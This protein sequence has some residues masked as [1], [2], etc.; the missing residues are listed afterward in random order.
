MTS[1]LRS[2]VRY[3]RQIGVIETVDGYRF[4]G[5]RIIEFSQV[6]RD[7]LREVALR[8]IP[9]ERQILDNWVALQ[10]R[11]WQPPGLSRDDLRQVFGQFLRNV[12]RRL[13]AQEVE[14]CTLD[15][16]ETGADLAQRQFPFEALI[17]SIHFFEESYMPHLIT[18]SPEQT[19]Q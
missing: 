6:T 1:S 11:A 17:V 19:R 3:H 14:Q 16:E 15:L 12:L 18:D 9:H 8:L 2:V 10:W 7:T 5:Y 4:A 13:E